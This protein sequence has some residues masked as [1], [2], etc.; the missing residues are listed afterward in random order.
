MKKLLFYSILLLFFA[1]CENSEAS[2]T[3]INE[4]QEIKGQSQTKIEKSAQ[5]ET[6]KLNQEGLYGF[7]VGPFEADEFKQNKKPSYT[8][9]INISI[10]EI[11]EEKIDGHSVVAGNSRPFSGTI[12]PISENIYQVEAK[13][14]GD[15]KYDG[16]FSFSID[17]KKMELIGTWEAYDKNLAVTKRSYTLEKKVFKYDENLEISEM[18]DYTPLI[19]EYGADNG[20]SEFETVTESISQ[21]NASNTVLKKEDVE[22]MYKGDLEIIRNAI[23]ARHGYTFQ[24]RKMRYF[25]DSVDWYIPVYTDITNQLTY[26]EKKNIDLLKRYEA[27]SERYY[28]TFGR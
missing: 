16:E 1:A 15:D 18:Y 9:K 6:P 24:N 20:N 4:Q 28:D 26:L 12:K 8:N 2:K 3:A 14:P 11:K 17:F 25:F 13:E 27:H 19:E 5:L 10:D 23:Y 22:N 21:F 7:Y